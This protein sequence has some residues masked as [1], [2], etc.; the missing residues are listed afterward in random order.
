[1]AGEAQRTP[2]ALTCMQRGA[3][4]A[5][6]MSRIC[7]AIR[8]STG[9]G[10]RFWLLVSCFSLAGP[11]GSVTDLAEPLGLPFAGCWAALLL[12]GLKLGLEQVCSTSCWKTD[13]LIF[14]SSSGR[15]CLESVSCAPGI[16]RDPEGI[17]GWCAWGRFVV[18]E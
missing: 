18:G 8:R 4:L 13:L 9:E 11:D 5:A 1:M 14:A 17:R 7:L 12:L 6:S 2:L 16:R 15:G 3:R 10:T